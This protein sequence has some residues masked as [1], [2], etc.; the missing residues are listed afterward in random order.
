MPETIP[1]TISTQDQII[2]PIVPVSPPVSPPAI[3]ILTPTPTDVK[4]APDVVKVS[5]WQKIL[6]YIKGL[7]GNL[8]LVYLI[9]NLICSI[10][11]ITLFVQSKINHGK[12]VAQIEAYTVNKLDP[13]M[14][15]SGKDDIVIIDAINNQS[16]AIISLSNKIDNLE[17]ALVPKVQIVHPVKT[18]VKEPV[19]EQQI[20]DKKDEVKKESSSHWYNPFSW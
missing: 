19:A 14:E 6:N 16:T 7:N 3:H 5:F 10:L 12:E 18:I 11:Y 8:F 20:G 4:T 15:A 13:F 17:K 9:I 1:S 2:A